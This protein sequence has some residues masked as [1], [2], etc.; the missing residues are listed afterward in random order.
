M[1]IGGLTPPF[2]TAGNREH[3]VCL[4]F[5]RDALF[6]T[7]L[8]GKPEQVFGQSK[9]VLHADPRS[10]A[11]ALGVAVADFAQPGEIAILDLHRPAHWQGTIG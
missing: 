5:S 3:S 9:A 6:Q 10:E 7:Q 4:F 8:P 11:I 1:G 2:T